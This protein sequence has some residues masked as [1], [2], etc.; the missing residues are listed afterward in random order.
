MGAL[1]YIDPG[2]G[3]MLFT[4]LIGVLSASVYSLRSVFSKLKFSLAGGKSVSKDKTDGKKDYIIF[5]DSKRYW[6]VFK[7][8]CDEFE[9]RQIVIYYFTASSD[10]PA[11]NENYEYVK[12][13]YVGEGNKAFARLNM[14]KAYIC[15]ST[16]PGLDVLQ[17]RRSKDIDYYVHIYHDVV[18][19]LGYRMFGTDFYDAILLTGSH[20][21]YYL[22][23]LE[24]LRHLPQKEMVVTG[25]TYM[26]ALKEKADS[27]EKKTSDTKLILLAPSWG[28]S[29]ILN[30]FGEKI[31]D[32]LINTGYKIA[33]RPHPQTAYSD[34]Q[35]LKELQEKYPDSEK[36]S[37]NADNDNF[38]ILSKSDV[39][40]TDFSGIIFDYCLVFDKPLIYA[41]T[42]L[43]LA[44]YDAAWIDEPLWRFEVLPDLGIKLEEKDFDKMKDII[45]N[46]FTNDKYAQGRREVKETVWHNIGEA[47][48]KTVDYLVNK[49]TELEESNKLEKH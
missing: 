17:W 48:S 28:P 4:I 18:E 35:M 38:D 44:P 34:P 45:D 16:T 39:L 2:T 29:S 42:S 3:S 32:A 27:I 21:E 24:E 1:L 40:I 6:N 12:T 43:D 11:L 37:W 47:A 7:P 46:L 23:K 19:G 9:R 10:D 36:L 26:D 33:I 25:S 14:M 13:E 49:R 20:Q 22:R 8:V 41:D 15:L 31:I 30:R 5:S